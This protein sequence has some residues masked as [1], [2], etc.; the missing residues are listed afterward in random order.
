M[1]QKFVLYVASRGLRRPVDDDL[2]MYPRMEIMKKI[3]TYIKL[4]SLDPNERIEIQGNNGAFI[5]YENGDITS[6]LYS[7]F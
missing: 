2:V 7:A 3:K 1:K 5:I 4:L 6:M